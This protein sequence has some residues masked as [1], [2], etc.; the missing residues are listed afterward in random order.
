[1]LGDR[2]TASDFGPGVR[3]T[4]PKG[5]AASMPTAEPVRLS[6]GRVAL[7]ASFLSILKRAGSRAWLQAL[8]PA[9]ATRSVAP[10]R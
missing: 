5:N 6:S 7:E 8:P 2:C 3:T 10:E 1:M 9:G 4:E